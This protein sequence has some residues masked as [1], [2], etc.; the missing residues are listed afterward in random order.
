L[1][2]WSSG[3]KQHRWFTDSGDRTMSSLR[4]YTYTFSAVRGVQ[5]QQLFYQACVPFRVLAAMLKLDD[6]ADVTKR[7][8]GLNWTLRRP[9]NCGFL[10]FVSYVEL[11][12]WNA[13][14]IT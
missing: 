13:K 7:S 3:R 11:P 10:R 6:D 5:G 12:S 2:T 8:Q 14:S 1:V 4:D 9:L